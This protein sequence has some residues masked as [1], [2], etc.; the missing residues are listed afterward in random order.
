[1]GEKG[2]EIAMW[3][4]LKAKLAENPGIAVFMMTY[5]GEQMANALFSCDF[6]IKDLEILAWLLGG[7]YG[8]NQLL[9]SPIPA[10]DQWKQR[11]G[12]NNGTG[13]PVRKV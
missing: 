6:N 13:A 8:M 10:L 11:G 7:R 4:E 3:Q 5:L 1:M 2:Q 12:L 9:G